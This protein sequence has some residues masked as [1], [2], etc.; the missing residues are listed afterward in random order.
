MGMALLVWVG[1]GLLK[2]VLYLFRSKI[3]DPAP[4]SIVT[5]VF[6]PSFINFVVH[7]LNSCAISRPPSATMSTSRPKSAKCSTQS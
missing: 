1:G 3:G 4:A 2:W 6:S 7:T 5:G